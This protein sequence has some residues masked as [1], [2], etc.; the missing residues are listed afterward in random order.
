MLI[1]EFIR[2]LAAL[3]ALASFAI[4]ISAWSTILGG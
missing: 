1:K 4:M 2:E 3:C